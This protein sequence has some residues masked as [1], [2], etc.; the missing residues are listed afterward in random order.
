MQ[1]E[2]LMKELLMKLVSTCGTSWEI[3]WMHLRTFFNLIEE[4]EKANF[5]VYFIL[6]LF[7]LHTNR[8]SPL[9]YSF[10]SLP[11]NLHLPTPERVRPPMQSQQSWAHSVEAEPSSPLPLPPYIKAKQDILS[12][13]NGLQKTSSCTRDRSLSCCHESQNQ[14]RIQY[15]QPHADLVWSH[16]GSSEV[17]LES[18]SSSKFRSILSL[19]FP[20]MILTNFVNIISPSPLQLN[21]HSLA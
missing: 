6:F 11:L 21:S 12:I 4:K 15:Y 18:M 9:L 14:T 10:P 13:W 5:Y 19:D 2:K 7:I 1:G 3:L 16:A 8:S 20:I 17:G